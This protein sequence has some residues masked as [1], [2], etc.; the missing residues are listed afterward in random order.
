MLSNG[1]SFGGGNTYGEST[2]HAPGEGMED[3]Q[4]PASAS[5]LFA[6]ITWRVR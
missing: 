1:N 4:R 3:G 2:V 5:W 6:V